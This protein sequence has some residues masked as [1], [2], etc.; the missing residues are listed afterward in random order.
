MAGTAEDLKVVL[1]VGSTLEQWEDVMHGQIIGGVA[2]FTHATRSCNGSSPGLAPLGCLVCA[3]VPACCA[4]PCPVVVLTFVC[5]TGW[6]A[7]SAPAL[8]EQRAACEA[9]GLH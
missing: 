1:C 4:L 7:A 5:V 6:A 9:A 8:L 2:A 3:A